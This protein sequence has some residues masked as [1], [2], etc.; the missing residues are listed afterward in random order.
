M[1]THPFIAVLA[2]CAAASLAASLLSGAGTVQAADR[3]GRFVVGPG[4]QGPRQ[5]PPITAAELLGGADPAVSLGQWRRGAAKA[6]SLSLEPRLTVVRELPALWRLE[7]G[8]D[9]DPSAL[10]VR[11]QLL[12]ASAGAGCVSH[13]LDS[14]SSVCVKIIPLPARVISRDDRHTLIEG[15][16]RLEIDLGSTRR[17]GAYSGTLSYTVSVY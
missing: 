9:V 13:A 11:Y 6:A 15:G 4:L 7:T 16:A 2:L 5:L 17:A 12:S 8:P 14:D 1:P 10:D 3:S